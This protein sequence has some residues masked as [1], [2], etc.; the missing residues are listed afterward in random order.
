MALIDAT[1]IGKWKASQRS[2]NF[3]LFRAELGPDDFGCV[4]PH[5]CYHCG[6]IWEEPEE[7]CTHRGCGFDSYWGPE[8]DEYESQCPGCGRM[9]ECGEVDDRNTPLKAV[10][11][12]KVSV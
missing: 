3:M 2:F 1:H 11:R 12:R 8:P 4:A 9:E 7:V 5:W 10:S 6:P